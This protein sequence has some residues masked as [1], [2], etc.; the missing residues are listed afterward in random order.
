MLKLLAYFILSTSLLLAACGGS[1]SSSNSNEQN[2]EN[3]DQIC[4][5][6]DTFEI[7]GIELTTALYDRDNSGCLSD[8]EYRVATRSADQIRS[9]QESGMTVDGKNTDSSISQIYTMKAI[10]SSEISDGNIQLH[11]NIDSGDFHLSL[12]TYSSGSSNERLKIYFDDES[13]AG[14]GGTEP[15]H[16]MSFPLP[17]NAGNLSYVFSCHYL[18]DLSV[19]CD[20]LVVTGTAN[21]GESVQTL[22]IDVTFPLRLTFSG[23][24]LPQTGYIIATFCDESAEDAVCLNNVAEIPVSFN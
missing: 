3:D 22:K 15:L 14:K 19:N 18:I 10:G 12:T 13:S 24:A 7:D 21:I 5:T 20:A 4:P 17:E 1:S 9:Q 2:T 16:A 8:F 6:G 23:Q 11:T